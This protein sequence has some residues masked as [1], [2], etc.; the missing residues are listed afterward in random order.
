MR[1]KRPDKKSALSLI[2]SAKKDMAFTLSLEVSEESSSTIV[3][4]SMSHSGS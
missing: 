4:T 2:E 3:E 1:I